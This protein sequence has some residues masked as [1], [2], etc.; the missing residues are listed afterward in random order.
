MSTMF[1]T[2]KDLPLLKGLSNE[3]FYEFLEKTNLQFINYADGD[4][5]IRSGENCEHIKFVISGELRSIRAIC[6][7]E[8]VITHSLPPGSVISPEYL[9]GIDTRFPFDAYAV[10]KV[11][12]LQFR[13]D[14]Y[15]KLLQSNDIFLMNF[16]NYLSLH[17]QRPIISYSQ[18]Y[19]RSLADMLAL[20]ISFYTK[21]GS[22]NISVRCSTETLGELSGISDIA[23]ELETLSKKGLILTDDNVI[24]ILSRDEMIEF[25]QQSR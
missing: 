3:Q 17:A 6:G 13:K 7:G 24:N 14:Q 5:V 22:R 10:G 15:M 19:G 16:S 4:T 21:S 20:W 1:D 8:V 23:S 25:A 12:M 11:S 18:F 9:F 2:L